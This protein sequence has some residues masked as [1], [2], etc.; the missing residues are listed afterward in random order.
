MA[1]ILLSC[2]VM[3]QVL[4]AC[5]FSQDQSVAKS[6]QL[7]WLVQ[8]RYSYNSEDLI[9]HHSTPEILS[10]KDLNRVTEWVVGKR[11]D[12]SCR[13][14]TMNL[15]LHIVENKEPYLSADYFCVCIIKNNQCFKNDDKFRD[16]F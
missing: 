6:Y 7:G 10:T 14:E 2:L 5:K 4:A 16:I 12:P 8:T 13:L 1:K 9:R 3:L 11:V 15:R